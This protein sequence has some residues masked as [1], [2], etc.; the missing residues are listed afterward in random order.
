MFDFLLLWLFEIACGFHITC[1]WE[2]QSHSAFGLPN[3]DASLLSMQ[4]KIRR[5]RGIEA[6][7]RG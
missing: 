7:K 1:C 6:V 2:D 4:V 3:V 5:D